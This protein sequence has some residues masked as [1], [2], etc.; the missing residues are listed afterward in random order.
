MINLG[1]DFVWSQDDVLQGKIVGVEDCLVV[2]V[3]TTDLPN[4]QS[5]S[6]GKPIMVWIHGG[7]L[8]AGSGS[9]QF[10]GPDFIMDHDVVSRY[11]FAYFHQ[12]SIDPITLF[13][14]W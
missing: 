11:R 6:K 7:G 13:R 9:K 3:Y 14:L 10:Y 1:K 12:T 5:K 8:A 2:N 4:E